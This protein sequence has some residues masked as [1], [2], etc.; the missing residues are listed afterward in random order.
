[1]YD[2]Q[3]EELSQVNYYAPRPYAEP[4]VL[5]RTA[6]A[7]YSSPYHIRVWGY[8]TTALIM[9]QAPAYTYKSNQL[10][11]IRKPQGP[12]TGAGQGTAP[13]QGIYTGV[14]ASGCAGSGVNPYS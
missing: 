4:A 14:S 9:Y 1:M 13:A 8:R 7:A 10:Y 12:N 2:P 5:A 3:V 6:P 11:Q